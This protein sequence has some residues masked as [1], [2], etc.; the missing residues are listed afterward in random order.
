M[1]NR[2]RTKVA[3]SIDWDSISLGRRSDAEDAKLLS[4]RYGIEIK[5]ST[6]ANKRESRKIRKFDDR[7]TALRG[8][9]CMDRREEAQRATGR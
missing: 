9:A 4:A 2:R 3:E 6:V 7:F 1:P 5:E 8:E